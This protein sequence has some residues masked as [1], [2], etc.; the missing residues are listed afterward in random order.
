MHGFEPTRDVSKLISSGMESTSP[1]FDT[2]CD[3]EQLLPAAAH[4]ASQ[5]IPAAEATCQPKPGGSAGG[6]EGGGGDGSATV[7]MV[8]VRMRRT[9]CSKVLP[10]QGGATLSMR[11]H[12]FIS[13]GQSPLDTQQYA[14]PCAGFQA[15]RLPAGPQSLHLAPEYPLW[16]E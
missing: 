12:V 13:M 7:A 10:L 1:M 9:R 11:Q 2:I 16:P 4:T 5:D 14:P 3:A 6:G 8:L 15:P